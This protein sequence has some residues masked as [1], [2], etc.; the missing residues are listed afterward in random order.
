MSFSS[1]FV[2]SNINL[3]KQFSAVFL[4]FIFTIALV[5]HTAAAPGDLDTTF[6]AG[7]VLTPIGSGEDTASSVVVQSDGKIVTAGSY[8]NGSNFDFAVLRYNSDGTLDTTFG[9]GGKAITSIGS[10]DEKADA[11]IIQPD[12][13]IIAAGYY[14]NGTAG[15]C[16]L[17][18]YNAN[19]TLDTTFGSGGKVTTQ[20]SNS[21][22]NIYALAIQSD[23]RIVAAGRATN[24]A[25]L[26]DFVVLRY[27]TNGTLDGSFDGDGFRFANFFSGTNDTA[28]AIAV[29][30]DGKIVVAGSTYN[31]SSYEFALHRINSNGNALFDDNQCWRGKQRR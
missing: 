28:Q 27:N 29:Q 10:G 5:A 14:I 13:K 18:R 9:T 4:G 21:T 31:G 6:G 12:G 25:S 22:E 2:C 30:T 26:L 1:L 17:V 7:K 15:D 20:T 24:G 3:L 8:F 23:G 19:G 16:A 11:V